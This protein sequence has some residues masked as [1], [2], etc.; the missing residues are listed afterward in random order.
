MSKLSRVINEMRLK[1]IKLQRKIKSF[2]YRK[3]VLNERLLSFFIE[4]EPYLNRNIIESEKYLFPN[5]PRLS[6]V[7]NSTKSKNNIFDP[8]LPSKEPLQPKRKVF[9]PKSI[10]LN[11]PKIVLFTR[12]L[13]LDLIIDSS[14]IYD[15]H[16]AR[17]YEK[18]Y[19]YNIEN[20]TPIQQISIGGCHTT[21]LNSKGKVFCWGWNNYGQCCTSSQSN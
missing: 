6:N 7:S 16:W 3:K 14:E 21:V 15:D 12:I 11:D 10:M 13:D 17:E 9:L 1:A 20:N 2:V 8:Y 19:N 18:L 5:K 4:E